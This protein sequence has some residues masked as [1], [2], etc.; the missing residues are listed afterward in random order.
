MAPTATKRLRIAAICTIYREHSHAQH[1]VDRFLEGYHWMGKRHKPAMDLVSLYVDQVLQN[2]LSRDRETRF[3]NLKI[4]PTIAEALTRGGSGLAVDGVL[5]IAEHGD[6]GRTEKG[7]TRYP[8]F[9]FFREIVEVFRAGGRSVPVFN[10]KHLS[11]N[12]DEAIQMVE[13]SRQLGFAFMAGSSLPVTFR[14]PPVDMPLGAKVP[15]ALSIAYGHVDSYD[16]HAIEMIQCMVERRAGGERGVQWLRA[17]RGERFWEAQS[18]GAWS[19]QLF[20]AALCRCHNLTL[21]M[22][23]SSTVVPT[24]DEVKKTVKEPIAYQYQHIDGPKCTM[25]LLNGL[26]GAFTFAAHVEGLPEPLSTN[27]LLTMPWQ[28]SSQANF[29]NPL[30]RH[31]EQMFLTGTPVYPVERTLLTTGL[32]AAGVDSLHAGQKH[33]DTPHLNIAYQPVEESL[34]A[35]E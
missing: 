29:F 1:I 2:D 13:L 23:G 35:T 20:E 30:V 31:V 32:T 6:Y 24:I 17:F 7:Q 12:W 21:P 28:L 19:P 8:R 34:F 4:Y 10:D 25:I 18:R 22:S 11:W 15:E 27:M 33:L 9:R 16:I 3:A 5:L 26:V 14:L